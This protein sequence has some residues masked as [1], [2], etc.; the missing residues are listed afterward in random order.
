M[1]EPDIVR[2]P[3]SSRQHPWA[4]KTA[5]WLAMR[6]IRPNWISMVSIL[7]ALCGGGSLWLS[8]FVQ[9]D[10]QSLLYVLAAVCIQ[11]RLLCN[12]FDGMVAIEGG[13]QTPTGEVFN[14]LPDRIADMVLLIATGYAITTISFGTTL[15]WLAV[16]LALLTAYVRILGGLVVSNNISPDP[17]Q[18]NIAWL[19]SQSRWYLQHLQR[20]LAS[21]NS[22]LLVHC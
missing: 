19:C 4:Q 21:R 20:P 1:T 6:G 3:I 13:Q 10:T 9:G 17:W 12:L 15:G 14:D 8:I 18:S 5:H 11:L 2:R 16:V 22:H 7:F